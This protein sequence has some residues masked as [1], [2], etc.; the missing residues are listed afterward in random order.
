[1][2]P[3]V[4]V[5]MPSY[6]HSRFIEEAIQSVLNQ[7][8]D[9]FELIII[10]DSSSDNSQEII[11]KF[12]EIDSRIKPIFHKKNMGIA[13]T[14]NDG[15]RASKGEFIAFIASDDVWVPNKL[16]VQLEILARNEDLVVWSE[17]E[18]IDAN[19]NPTGQAFTER[20]NATNRKKSGRIFEELLK[21]NFIF[22]SSMILKRKNLDKIRFDE[23]LKYLND[24]KFVVDLAWKYEYHFIKN[25]LAKYRIHGRNTILSDKKGWL[26][27]AVRVNKYFLEQYGDRISRKLRAMLY[28]RIASAYAQLGNKRAAKQ[29]LYKIL[30]TYPASLYWGML[31]VILH[32]KEDSFIRNVLRKWYLSINK[33][34]QEV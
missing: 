31:L 2:R 17:G 26:I 14:L 18:I 24:Y 25:P 34:L 10:D 4:S 27:D 1:M 5:I 20:H 13:R 30:S 29:Y 12:A 19:G 7:T 11:Q 6:N 21:G 15:L 28:Y 3:T 23:S 22:G 16:E 8:F 33:I 9:D 32:T